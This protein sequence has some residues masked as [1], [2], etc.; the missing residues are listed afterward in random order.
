M[1]KTLKKII[2]IILVIVIVPLVIII[3]PVNKNNKYNKNLINTL[4]K[5]TKLSNITYLNKDN[6]YYI[7]VEDKNNIIV[8]DLNYKKIASTK[9]DNI[10]LDNR[11][12]SYQ[13]NN[14]YYKEKTL[15]KDKITYRYYD[16][17]TNELI[18]EVL[19]GGT[20]E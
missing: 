3:Y 10:N 17:N 19:V 13:R 11:E 7:V 16:I 1:K 12:L 14:I 9:L 15:D 18:Y 2:P 5:E 4:K 8:Y 20:Y 6:N